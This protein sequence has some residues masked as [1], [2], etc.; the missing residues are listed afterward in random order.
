MRLF[1]HV[2]A[3]YGLLVGV[4]MMFFFGDV[5]P[6]L[7]FPVIGAAVAGILAG[8]YENGT[9]AGLEAGIFLAAVLIGM[10]YAPVLTSVR[11]LDAAL[12]VS[13]GFCIVCSFEFAVFGFLSGYISGIM[14]DYLIPDK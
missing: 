13:P 5:L 8:G 2:S 6:P 4:I 14:R 3:F 7:V 9:R 12:A 11:Y 10:V 1:V